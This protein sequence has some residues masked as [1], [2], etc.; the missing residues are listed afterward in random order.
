MRGHYIAVFVQM[1][2]TSAL[3]ALLACKKYRFRQF[4]ALPPLTWTL[5]AHVSFQSCKLGKD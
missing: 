1:A 4:L 2:I 5:F 3:L